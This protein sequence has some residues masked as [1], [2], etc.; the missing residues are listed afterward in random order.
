MIRKLR[1]RK[2]S[3]VSLNDIPLEETGYMKLYPDTINGTLGQDEL[4]VQ[5][6]LKDGTVRV[7]TKSFGPN[8]FV[9]KKDIVVVP[10][11][12]DLIRAYSE[13]CKRND[14]E[15]TLEDALTMIDYIEEVSIKELNNF[16]ETKVKF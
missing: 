4:V 15:C 8:F 6:I 1:L 7:N 16:I 5:E 11:E 12:T 14:Y 9:Y 2:G 10:T 13:W 3:K